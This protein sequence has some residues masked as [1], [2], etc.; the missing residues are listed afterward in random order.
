[1]YIFFI[2]FYLIMKIIRDNYGYINSILVLILLIPIILLMLL[3]ISQN[4]ILVNN[5][6]D[7]FEG[8]VLSTK[9]NDFINQINIISMESM[10]NLSYK[11]V[12]D[13]VVISNS[14][15]QLKMCIQDAVNNLSVDYQHKGL[16][17]DCRIINVVASTNPFE[18]NVYYRIN[19][20]FINDSSNKKVSQKGCM[21]VS[22]VNSEYPV[23][24]PYPLFNAR[25]HI[26]GNE[27]VYDSIEDDLSNA[28]DGADSGLI[29]KKCV[30]DDYTLHGHSNNSIGDC[31]ENHYYHLSHD[32]LCIF[33]RLENRSSCIH[34]GLETFVVSHV[35]SNQSVVSADHVLFN[36]TG[37]QYLGDVIVINS[38]SFIYL[39]NGHGSKYG[40]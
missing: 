18:Y 7:I 40:L 11:S 25:V 28:Y 26:S 14:S 31:L 38:S 8:N 39:D 17:V 29:I 20:S 22:I 2:V 13:G 35:H 27:Y 32:G 3:S 6:V 30:Y 1:M 37:N 24:D 9:T 16:H 10:H 15:R 19:S 23:Y 33:C 34:N 21:N 36:T 12:Y 5:S 4:E